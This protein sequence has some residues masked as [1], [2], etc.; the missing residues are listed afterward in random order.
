M[1]VRGH[2]HDLEA[3]ARGK[4]LLGSGQ[5]SCCN[6]ELWAGQPGFDPLQGKEVCLYS[7]ALLLPLEPTQR[8]I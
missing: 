1:E 3:I 7:T 4:D 2:L 5:L 8:A 6:D